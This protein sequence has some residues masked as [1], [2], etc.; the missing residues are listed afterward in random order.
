MIRDDNP[1]H[2]KQISVGLYG[3]V[4]QDKIM[5][6][7]FKELDDPITLKQ[8]RHTRLSVAMD[9]INKIHGLDSVVLGTLPETIS[10]FSGTKIAFTRIPEKEEFHE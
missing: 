9:K 3:L 8:K 5:P 4:A 1:K 10:R 6:D 7:M 2:I